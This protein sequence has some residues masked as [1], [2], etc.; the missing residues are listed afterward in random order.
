MIGSVDGLGVTGSGNGMTGSGAN[1]GL[2]AAGTGNGSSVGPGAAGTG[3]GSD[4]GD[5]R[6]NIEVEVGEQ[7]VGGAEEGRPQPP[8]WLGQRPS[9]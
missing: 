6:R 3:S 7:G 1:A 5:G 8:D 2:G 9:D 4:L